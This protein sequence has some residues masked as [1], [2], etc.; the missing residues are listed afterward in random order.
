MYYRRDGVKVARSPRMQ[1]SDVPSPVGID[2][3]P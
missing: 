1:E 2:L 3:S